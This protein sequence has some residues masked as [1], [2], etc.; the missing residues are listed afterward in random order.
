MHIKNIKE[1]FNR[2]KN[3]YVSDDGEENN[4]IFVKLNNVNES[5]KL[6]DRGQI[7]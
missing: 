1:Y 4:K 3:G 5:V 6:L 7:V 2:T